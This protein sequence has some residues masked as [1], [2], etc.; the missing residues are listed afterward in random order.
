MRESLNQLIVLVNRC[1]AAFWDF[2]W[3]MLLQVIVLVVILFCLDLLLRAENAGSGSILRIWLLVLAKLLLPTNIRTPASLAYWLPASETTVATAGS[4]V[5]PTAV[6]P[7]LGMDPMAN[8]FDLSPPSPEQFARAESSNPPR[9]D[10]PSGS[11]AAPAPVAGVRLD[12][13]GI[14]LAGW[15]AAVTT[16]LG[17][18]WHRARMVRSLAHHT[19]AAPEAI[20][21]ILVECLPVVSLTPRP[22]Q[23]RISDRLGSPAIC[24]FFRPTILLPSQGLDKLEREQIRLIF[25]HELVHWKRGDL[26]VNCLQT[27]LQI[28]YFYNPAVW[29]ASARVRRL[30]EEA[31]DETVLVMTQGEAERYA[32]TLLDL[33]AFSL[34]PAE[35]MLRLIGVV[36]SR[37]ALAGRIRRIIGRPT[38]RTARVGLTG[39]AAILLIGLLLVPMASS[40]RPAVV[41]QVDKSSKEVKPTQST[42]EPDKASKPVANPN[43]AS[44]E[45]PEVDVNQAKSVTAN[46]VLSGR[47]TD[48]T[49]AP[50]TDA[51]IE[52]SLQHEVI[53]KTKTDADGKYTFERVTQAGEYR[54][55]ILTQRWVGIG[56][57]NT[58]DLPRVELNPR[59][60]T[61]RD[62][63]LPRACRLKLEIVNEEGQPIRKVHVVSRLIGDANPYDY[64]NGGFT[65]KLG[66]TTVHG[67][68]PSADQKHDVAA[69]SDDYALEHIEITLDNPEII[70]ERKLV[71]R[72]GQPVTGKVLCSDGKPAAGWSINAMPIWW[73]FV[74]SPNGQKIEAD[75][76]FTLPHVAPEK[77]NVDVSI[78]SGGG[79]STLKTVLSDVALPGDDGPLAITVDSPSPTA[80]TK[81]SGKLQFSGG[82]L[83]SGIHVDARSID[84]KYFGSTFIRPE[85]NSVRTRSNPSWKLSRRL[86][87]HRDRSN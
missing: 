83:K 77:Y 54:L 42:A 74:I 59:S 43:A 63:T 35:S 73:H 85:D 53:G 62:L 47:I 11:A 14:V 30:R 76:S 4:V 48:D 80:M 9:A 69:M 65:D 26:Q 67:L 49:G 56:A 52:L 19:A 46:G 27:V 38:P 84:G 41:A 28:L 24:G 68:K 1:G 79:S 57:Q 23:L 64:V 21:A 31:V 87:V 20:E 50:V 82:V 3:P 75:G 60:P 22:M 78:P 18:L 15:F 45:K 55:T 37:K 5:T 71:L 61:V 25:L 81:L 32:S 17:M 44:D 86:R 12:W 8:P 36:E 10:V 40:D 39:M 33:A 7:A 16:L 66:Q 51:E 70:V 58:R 29:F 72:K 2:A 6:D 13:K 34:Q